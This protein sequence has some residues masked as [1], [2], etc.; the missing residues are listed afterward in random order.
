MTIAIVAILFVGFLLIATEKMNRM[1]S[2][3]VAIFMGVTVWV[4]YVCMGAD[5][6]AAEH[7]VDFQTFQ[8]TFTGE[9][10]V[11]VFISEF[12]FLPYFIKTCSTVLFLFCTITIVEVLNN[13]RCFD[14][15]QEWLYVGNPRKFLFVL[16]VFTAFLSINLDNLITSCLMLS[17]THSLVSNSS[18]RRIYGFAIIV[19]ANI[20]GAVTVIGD[21]NSFTLWQN[22]LITPTHYT[23]AII[24]PCLVSLV[25]TLVLLLPLLPHHLSTKHS[26][27]PYRG[28]DKSLSRWQ[29]LLM[30]V[31]GLGGLWFV[32][33]FHR[34]TQFPPL[35]GAVCVLGVLL[36]V[37]ELCNRSF[38][39]ADVMVRKRLPLA[40]Q[41]A[42]IQKMLFFLGLSLSFGALAE[43][44]V[45]S[46]L[47]T[48]LPVFLNE[49]Y[50]YAI[51]SGVFASIFNGMSAILANV[52]MASTE[53]LPIT[54]DISQNG[55]YWPL[56]SFSVAMGG[57][58]LCIGTLEGLY[59]MTLEELPLKWY[60]KHCSWRVFAGWI[61]GLSIF[62]FIC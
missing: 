26:L 51:G 53:A 2:S 60:I 45:L 44:G 31:I 14:F 37:N 38:L 17:I 13:N 47:Q 27:L 5:Y 3:A 54:I 7:A 61:A 33:T 18:L 42:N 23:T 10:S 50:T 12:V 1:N 11:K 35:M 9:K 41:Y 6:L 16:T 43:T 25:V 39:S 29:R 24:L 22:K 62:L 58:L 34:I 8:S 46:K 40:L 15:L 55:V 49:N 52:S 48:I 28:D 57:C 32:P 19:T 21:V 20:A 4:L 30:L 56:L 36:I 59:L